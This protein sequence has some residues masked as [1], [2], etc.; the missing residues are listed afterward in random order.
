MHLES[1]VHVFVAQTVLLS[2]AQAHEPRRELVDLVRVDMLK[3][4]VRCN[5]H[6]NLIGNRAVT[7]PPSLEQL[8]YHRL[9][10]LAVAA[11]VVIE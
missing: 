1:K 6:T 8:L 11:E 4:W 9:Q 5:D 3:Q 10:T 2:I 7:E